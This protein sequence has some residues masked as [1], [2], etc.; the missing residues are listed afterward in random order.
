[1]LGFTKQNLSYWHTHSY[2]TQFRNSVY[3][4]VKRATS[5]F[6]LSLEQ[7]EHLA[8]SAGLSLQCETINLYEYLDYQGNIRTLCE[9]AMVSER[10]F[11]YYKVKI[12]SKQALLALTLALVWQE[13]AID[14]LLRKCGYCLSQSI[15]GDVVIRW[16]VGQDGG[17]RRMEE[18]LLFEINEV[19]E[20]MG[21]PLL[22]TRQS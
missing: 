21:L 8:N 22:M 13:E 18:R 14:G 4:V 10:M 12:P 11:R 7:S 16:Y 2:S 1:M 5:L 15:A 3:E 6:D 9:R 20:H 19:L 17:K